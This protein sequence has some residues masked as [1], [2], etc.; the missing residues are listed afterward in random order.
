MSQTLT[1]VLSLLVLDPTLVTFA[2]ILWQL[3][4]SSR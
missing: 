4:G 1:I 2:A 3:S